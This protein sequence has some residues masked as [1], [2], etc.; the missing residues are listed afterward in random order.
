MA[1]KQHDPPIPAGLSKKSADLFVKLTAEVTFPTE[2]APM[3]EAWLRTLDVCDKLQAQVD[4]LE[5]YRCMG[6]QKQPVVPP[7]LLALAKFRA[8]AVSQCRA[9]DIADEP[10]EQSAPPGFFTASDFGRRGAAARW[11]HRRGA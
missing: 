7:E 6:S 1:R 9:L 4:A 3:L 5:S 2:K 8:L 11:G 10:E